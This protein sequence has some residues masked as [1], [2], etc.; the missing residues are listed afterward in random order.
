MLLDAVFDRFA[1]DSPVAVMVRALLEHALPAAAVDE[2][3]DRRAETQYTRE[4]LFSEVV[5]LMALVVCGIHPS[6]HAAYQA[7]RQ[8]FRVSVTAVYDKLNGVEPRVS[9]ALVGETAPRLAGVIGALGATLPDWLPG[10]PVRILDGNCLAATEHRLRELRRTTAGPL[11]GKSLVVL[12]PATMLA[13]DVFPCEDGHAQERALLHAV[14]PTV[15]PGQVWI[16][17]RNFC[18]LAFLAGVRRRGG[19]FLVR[20]HANL[21]W[22]P[23]TG[24]RPVGRADGVTVCEQEVRLEDP[25]G[26]EALV[27]RRL[28]LTLPE[29]TR[30]GDAVIHL[31]SSLPAGAADGARLAQLYRGRW[32]IEGLFGVLV[33]ALEGEQPRLGYPRAALFAFCVSLVAY[34]VLAVVRAALRAE[35]GREAVAEGVSTYHLADEIRGIYRGMMVAVP[36][37]HWLPFARMDATALAAVLR[38]LARRADL[39]AYR[40]HPRGPKRPAPKRTKDRRHPHVATAR[41]IACRHNKKPSP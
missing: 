28:R 41:L 19:H 15:E 39:S 17:D 12:D 11:P 40:R 6:P 21:P 33:S 14:L 23:V 38:G 4:L 5:D 20:Q 32:T 13:V 26:G 10:Y 16:E 37:G 18:T 27:V 35:Y 31:L 9:A 36:P 25:D 3:F 1:K 22:R 7:R 34:N 2:L 8:D 29:P 24:M 30:D